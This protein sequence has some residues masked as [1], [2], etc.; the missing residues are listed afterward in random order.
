ML[1]HGLSFLFTGLMKSE[2]LGLFRKRIDETLQDG[3]PSIRRRSQDEY[4]Q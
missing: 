4:V 1:H 3:E 2:P